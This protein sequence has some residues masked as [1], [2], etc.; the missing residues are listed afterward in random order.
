MIGH[1]VVWPAREVKLSDLPDL[2]SS[3]L[4]N[5]VIMLNTQ[6]AAEDGGDV[7][8]KT[9]QTAYRRCERSFKSKHTVGLNTNTQFMGKVTDGLKQ[10]SI[11]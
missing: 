8:E 5:R 10:V 4:R 11:I 3:S 1:A 9:E 6:S 2:M 7:W